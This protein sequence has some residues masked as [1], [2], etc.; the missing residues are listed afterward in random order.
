MKRLAFLLLLASLVY[1]CGTPAFIREAESSIGGYW[2]LT[3]IAYPGGEKDFNVSLFN[4]VPAA[5]LEQSSWNFIPNNNTGSYE[6][7]GIG[8]GEGP[9]FFIWFFPE[10]GAEN[11][12]TDLMLKPTDAQYLSVSGNKGY[13][14][15]LAQLTEGRMVWKE[16]VFFE[17][18]PFTIKMNFKR[19]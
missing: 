13:R 12:E 16:T 8:C 9:N 14:I 19:N 2:E 4:E 5:C 10:A 18:E 1:S 3:D 17:G 11:Q 6:L 7:S 15:E